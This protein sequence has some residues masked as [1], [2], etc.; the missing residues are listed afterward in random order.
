MRLLLLAA[1]GRENIAGRREQS[2]FRCQCF[3]QDEAGNGWRLDNQPV[4]GSDLLIT[5]KV[6]TLFTG[7][8][9]EFD[10]AAASGAVVDRVISDLRARVERNGRVGM[11]DRD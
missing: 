10:H 6:D 11:A 1:S 2:G 3:D 4:G 5:W 9:F 7:D 8:Q